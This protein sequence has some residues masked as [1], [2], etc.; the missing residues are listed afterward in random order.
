MLREDLHAAVVVT[1]LDSR[2]LKNLRT[3]PPDDARWSAAFRVTVDYKVAGDSNRSVSTLPAVIGRYDV[4]EDVLQFTPRFEFGEGV[5]YRVDVD[6]AALSLLGAMPARLNESFVARFEI[7]KP[8]RSRTTHVVAVHPNAAELPENLLRWY[9]EFSAPMRIGEALDH[10]HLRDE[11]GREV[12]NVFLKLGQEL[13]DSSRTRLTLLLDPGR[14]KRGIRTN[15]EMGAPLIAGRRYTLSV[16]ADWQ[17]GAGAELRSGFKLPF[18][19]G[20]ADRRSPLP[21]SWGLTPP[22]A[23]SRDALEVAFGEPIDHAQASRMIWI[24]DAAGNRVPG[25]G[26]VERG[27][28]LWRF[29][30]SA[31]W[32]AE[33]YALQ[34]LSALEDV[35]GNN[36]VRVFDEDL[37]ASVAPSAGQ[38]GQNPG[39]PREFR[40]RAPT[41][42]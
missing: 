10:I 17:D 39:P 1:H 33:P 20:A 24:T 36:A 22:L 40:P 30:P 37:R 14:V 3:L 4:V 34:A 19:A 32:R 7:P 13:W 28:S 35:A 42:E 9:I 26:S 5:S 16:D 6:G 41:P 11:S 38:V 2:L 23:G 31:P 29:V 27:D 15:L 8:V 18:R 12:H 25:Q 21:A